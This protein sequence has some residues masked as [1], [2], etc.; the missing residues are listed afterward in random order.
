MKESETCLGHC[1]TSVIELHC[2]SANTAKNLI[3]LEKKTLS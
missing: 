1:Q 3:I 2:E